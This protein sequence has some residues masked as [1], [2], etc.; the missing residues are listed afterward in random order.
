MLNLLKTICN[1]GSKPE[2]SRPGRDTCKMLAEYIS[3]SKKR[4]EN[5]EI[6]LYVSVPTGISSHNAPLIW[7]ISHICPVLAIYAF[8]SIFFSAIW[9][10]TTFVCPPRTK[11]ILHVYVY[12]YTTRV[13]C[14]VVPWK[15][16]YGYTSTTYYTIFTETTMGTAAPEPHQHLQQ[17]KVVWASDDQGTS[18]KCLTPL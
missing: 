9:C 1:R 6:L 16:L 2:C 5:K 14:C 7:G 11:D 3:L 17:T 4:L 18:I 8:L 10:K 13:H 12:S 15:R